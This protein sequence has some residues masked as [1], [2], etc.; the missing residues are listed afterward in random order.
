MPVKTYKPVSFATISLIVVIFIAVHIVIFASMPNDLASVSKNIIVTKGTSLVS[1]SE[2][3]KREDLIQSKY[4]FLLCS[5]LIY[6]GRVVAGEYELPPGL[7]I[8]RIARKMAVG[9]R[10]IY[11][12]KIVEG[13]NL[14]TVAEAVE[15][16]GI[17]RGSDFLS[18][19]RDRSFLQRA[20]IAADSLEG[21]LSPDTYFYSRET[22]LDGF[23][24]TIVQRTFRFLGGA[25]LKKRMDEMHLN[26]H[27]LLSLASM[28]EKEAKLEE[29]KK[30]VSAVFA[31]RLRTGMS[32]D[33]DPTVIYGLAA[34]NR[35]LTKADLAF[36]NEYNTY[37][38]RG[39]PKGPICNPSR[40]SIL[41]ALNPAPLDYLYFVSRNDGS[42][43]FSRSMHE[44]NRY[45]MLYQKKK[46]KNH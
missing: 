31:N 40:S 19:A 30:L 26:V 4:L 34:F 33:C 15:S 24:E 22:D 43:V 9:E 11:T 12:L 44:H 3:L 38:L 2:Q 18:L 36:R 7:S 45:V 23:I 21:Y 20:N 39:L 16:A 46:T 10:K 37:R 28:I 25:D 32:L 13:Y 42:H 6:G 17:A 29:E 35:S 14:F 5:F 41:A 27:Q 8:I 1:V